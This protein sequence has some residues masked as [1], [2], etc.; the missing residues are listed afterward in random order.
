MNHTTSA[1]QINHGY[2]F[3]KITK[4]EPFR[5]E[6]LTMSVRLYFSE[7]VMKKNPCPCTLHM[8]DDK[9]FFLRSSMKL[10]CKVLMSNLPVSWSDPVCHAGLLPFAQH[11]LY[12]FPWSKIRSLPPQGQRCLDL[13][14]KRLVLWKVRRKWY[15][16]LTMPWHGKSM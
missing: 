12:F 3:V 6:K 1:R 15:A 7:K 5:L 16:P 13:F 9:P 11:F 4:W 8:Q 2:I 10:A 14:F